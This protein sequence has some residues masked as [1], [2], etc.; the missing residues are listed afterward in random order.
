MENDEENL[1][2]DSRVYEVGY[3]L[4][5]NIS[6]EEMLVV[7]GNLK[8]LLSS[9]N[10]E[11]ISDEIPKMITLA[12]PMS[13]VIQNMR[14]KFNTAYFGWIKF[15][16]NTNKIGEL[17]KKLNADLN[18]IR[19]LILKTVKENTIATKRFINKDSRRKMPILKKDIEN[20]PSIPINKEELD[21]EIDAMVTV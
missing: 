8:N 6:E 3:L 18:F 7:Y 13:K 9:L 10:G 17:K 4:L 11:I 19:F 14:N 2:I 15:N 20:T 21:K 1:E 5:P 12:Y 16:M